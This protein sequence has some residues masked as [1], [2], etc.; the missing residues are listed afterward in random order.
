MSQPDVS[1]LSVGW[2]IREQT[3]D[4]PDSVAFGLRY[5]VVAVDNG[6]REG[7]VDMLHLPFV[8]PSIGAGLEESR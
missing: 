4:C 6:L 2:N 1:V 5:E 7:S 3:R 8:G